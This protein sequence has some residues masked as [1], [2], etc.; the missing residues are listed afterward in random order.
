MAEAKRVKLEWNGA[1][2]SREADTAMK[3]SLRAAGNAAIQ[4]AETLVPVDTGE[5]KRSIFRIGPEKVDGNWQVEIEADARAV[6]GA[7]Y[8]GF[9]EFGTKYMRAQP[10]MRPARD[11]G[12]DR[13]KSE[14]RKR[15][16]KLKI[17]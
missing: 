15:F 11:V 9:V 4:Q 12:F 6:G 17:R 2:L 14:L 5:L 10:F 13:L 3:E 7:F 1:E 8:A 16:K